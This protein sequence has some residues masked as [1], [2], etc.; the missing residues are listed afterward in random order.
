MTRATLAFAVRDDSYPLDFA[1][2]EFPSGSCGA[3]WAGFTEFV[4]EKARDY[5]EKHCQKFVGLAMSNDLCEHSPDLCS[6][7][8]AELDIIPIVL[9]SSEEKVSW[10]LYE[11]NLAHK[12]LDELAESLA[13][14]C[15]RLGFHLSAEFRI[16]FSRGSRFFGPNQAP[17]PEVGIR[18]LVEVDAAF[19]LKL[20]RLGDYEKTVGAPT[21][22]AINKYA[23]DLKKRRVK[24]A[25]FS[26]TPQGG[27]V[28]LM[29][30]AMVR[31]AKVLGVDLRWYVLACIHFS[32]K[33]ASLLSAHY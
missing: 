32:T 5:Q 13:R 3:G 7:L 8:W 15:I 28:A 14:K 33:S 12:S 11:E 21:W 29:R 2:F 19:H 10:G 27:G 1:Q 20:T 25:F 22:A 31:F 6:R 9:R 30:H 16:F 26:A 4:L 24:I 23:G 17:I 18:G